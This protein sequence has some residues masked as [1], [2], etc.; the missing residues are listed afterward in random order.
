MGK[1]NCVRFASAA[2][3]VRDAE[4][5]G[6]AELEADLARRPEPD[7][8]L[9]VR[10]G[11]VGLDASAEHLSVRIDEGAEREV[12]A[13]ARRLALNGSVREDREEGIAAHTEHAAETDGVDDRVRSESQADVRTDAPLALAELAEAEESEVGQEEVVGLESDAGLDVRVLLEADDLRVAR[14]NRGVDDVVVAEVDVREERR[15]HAETGELLPG[16]TLLLGELVGGLVLGLRIEA[17]QV[18]RLIL[19]D[20]L[21]RD[22]G[23][24]DGG[25]DDEHRQD[26]HGDSQGADAHDSSFARYV[27]GSSSSGNTV[28][29]I[30]KVVKFFRCS[31]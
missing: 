16:I 18:F 5:V 10:Q 30:G 31:T 14:E 12:E 1:K 28:Y 8:I 3:E 6:E 29:T 21:G 17:L 9:A 15:R 23:H 24:G 27:E 26:E 2:D 4:V 25:G 19:L 11:P 7:L 20:L 22:D 13:V